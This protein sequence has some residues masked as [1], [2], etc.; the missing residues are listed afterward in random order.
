MDSVLMFVFP[1]K[2]SHTELSCSVL[3][4]FTLL[5]V[6]VDIEKYA[7][8]V[9]KNYLNCLV[10]VNGYITRLFLNDKHVYSNIFRTLKMYNYLFPVVF[11]NEISSVVLTRHACQCIWIYFLA[12]PDL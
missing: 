4:R 11:I 2:S 5:N 9:Y 10:S 6:I 12:I 8:I 3:I 1:S 7:Y